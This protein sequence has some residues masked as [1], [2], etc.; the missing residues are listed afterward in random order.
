MLYTNE[1]VKIPFLF[2]MFISLVPFITEF[3]EKHH[4]LYSFPCKA[5][6]WEENLCWALKQAGYGSNWKP[7]S[8]HR[9]GVDQTTDLGI[10]IGNKSGD[11]EHDYVKISGSRLTKHKN[12]AEKLKFLSEKKE[13]YIF[14]LATDKKEWKRGKKHYYF[15]VFNSDTLNYH[16][17]EWKEVMGSRKYNKDK[18]V[19]WKCTSE[20]FSAT[21]NISMSDQ[22]WTHVKLNAYEEI[23]DIVIR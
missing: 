19:G 7:N 15:I 12:I 17:Q 2:L 6:Y 18:I 14:C 22:L 16:E 23:Y 9:S 1:V 5:E 13:D 10:R 4:E 20:E 21:I 11:I 8:N 3:L